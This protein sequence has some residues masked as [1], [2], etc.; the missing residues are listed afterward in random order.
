MR[1]CEAEYES[2][3]EQFNKANKAAKESE[4][5]ARESQRKAEQLYSACRYYS[6]SVILF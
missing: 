2:T 5:L 3:I 1:R 4:E 6:T